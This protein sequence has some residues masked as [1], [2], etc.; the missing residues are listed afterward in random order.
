MKGFTARHPEVPPELRGTYLG[1]ASPP[2]IEHL[3]KLG[4]TAVELL[5]VHESVD[6]PFLQREGAHELLGLL[7]ARLLRAG[8]AVRPRRAAAS[9]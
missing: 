9:R 6:D 8:A 1:F 3:V 7:D 2:A 5:P 4:V